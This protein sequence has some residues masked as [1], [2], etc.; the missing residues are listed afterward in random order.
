MWSFQMVTCSPLKDLKS[1]SSFPSSFPWRFSR[2]VL[3]YCLEGDLAWK[4]TCGWRMRKTLYTDLTHVFC[5]AEPTK[6][7]PRGQPRDNSALHS[8]INSC[9]DPRG[10]LILK[11][12]LLGTRP[13][14][15]LALSDPK[16]PK[17]CWFIFF[18]SAL[19]L[20]PCLFTEALSIS[21]RLTRSVHPWP[22]HEILVGIQQGSQG[23][24][25]SNQSLQVSTCASAW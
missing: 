16:E 1:T 14:A 20:S 25:S 21:Q 15:T 9:K 10:S 8:K 19:S 24:Y 5:P 23:E 11:G 3:V 6:N 12:S 17:K 13:S 22:S 18:H 2:R 7:C 4:D